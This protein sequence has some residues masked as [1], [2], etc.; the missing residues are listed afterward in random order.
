MEKA[1]VELEGMKDAIDDA[2]TATQKACDLMA[3]SVMYGYDDFEIVFK[4]M[5]KDRNSI[6][7]IAKKILK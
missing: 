5:L 4:A 6:L 2:F 3:K 1:S 7:G